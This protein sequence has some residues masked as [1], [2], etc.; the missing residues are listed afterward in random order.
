MSYISGIIIVIEVT[1]SCLPK[2]N[3]I[4]I[5]GPK[6]TYYLYPGSFIVT[7][8]DLNS[9]ISKILNDVNYEGFTARG[10]NCYFEKGE[11]SFSYIMT[12]INIDINKNA[13]SIFEE[14]RILF[15]PLLIIFNFLFNEI[16]TIKRAFFFRKYSYGYK[17]IRMLEIPNFHKEIS[18]K[19]KLIEIIYQDDVQVIFPFILARICGKEK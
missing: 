18:E 15:K 17:F 2:L 7:L 16:F 12:R 13:D 9:E 3:S 14:L 5:K 4:R 1:K 8:K 11:D 6:N 10:G 19:S